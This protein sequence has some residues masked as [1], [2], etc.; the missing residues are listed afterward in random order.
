MFRTLPPAEFTEDD[1]LALATAMKAAPLD[2]SI[3]DHPH[4]EENS[5]I[6]TG[7]TYLGQFMDHDIT[8]DPASSLQKQNDPNGLID[9][10]TPK[11]DLDN[12][13]G[14]GPSDQ[15]YLYDDSGHL[16]LGTPLTGNPRDAKTKD[17]QRNLGG[18]GRAMIGD[19]RN[20][21]N[22]IVSQMQAAF[23]RFHNRVLDLMRAEDPKVPFEEVQ[24]VV[25]WHYQWVILHDFLPTI[26]GTDTLYSILPHLKSGKS[27][28]VDKPQLNF[29]SYKNYPFIPVE[30]SVAAYR[31]GHSMVGPFYRL[32]PNIVK[33]LFDM[34]ATK[35]LNGFRPMPS[36]WAI[37]WHLYFDPDNTQPAN[38]PGRVQKAFKID[39]SLVD[40]LGSL[41]FSTGIDSH[42]LAF[43]NLLRGKRFNLPSGQEVARFMDVEVIPDKKLLVGSATKAAQATNKSITDISKNF[44]DNAPLW[45]YIL[46]EAQQQFRR[47][48]TPIR[49]GAVGGRIVGE[50]I[51]GLLLGDSYSYL[52][53]VP[54]WQPRK[55]FVNKNGKFRMRELLDQA[56]LW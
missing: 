43:L 47:D 46:A 13:Y 5:G 38:G 11:F 26:I 9:F 7:Y 25:R 42:N 54:S 3:V 40:P 39:T 30:F 12:L 14:R 51:V 20:D 8:F 21:E 2:I 27:I 4:P 18:N 15:P 52:S 33:K 44:A 41:P 22:V 6:D 32:N 35:A 53:Q 48:D 17:L 1:L 36:D 49:L 50:V 28:Y 29:Y 34:D 37:D 24:E 55:D 10:R 45:F 56:S 19:P 31:F 23:V 16:L